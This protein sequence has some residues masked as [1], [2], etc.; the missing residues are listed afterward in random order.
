MIRGGVSCLGYPILRHNKKMGLDKLSHLSEQSTA[1]SSKEPSK[2][3][4]RVTRARVSASKLLVLC[5][6]VREAVWG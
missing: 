6:P 3:Q 4:H 2:V 5:T 1:K